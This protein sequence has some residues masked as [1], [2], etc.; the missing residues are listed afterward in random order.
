VTGELPPSRWEAHLDEGRD[1]GV[2]RVRP[3]SVEEQCAKISNEFAMAPWLAEP[4]KQHLPGECCTIAC[5]GCLD[6]AIDIFVEDAAIC[7]ELQCSGTHLGSIIGL[8]PADAIRG[9]AGG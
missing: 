2:P 6:D 8:L 3:C 1:A 4:L 9:S 7:H 5:N